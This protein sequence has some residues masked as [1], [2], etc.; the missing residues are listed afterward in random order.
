MHFEFREALR[1]CG[2]GARNLRTLH[3]FHHERI[4]LVSEI[5]EVAVALIL[6]LQVDT[7]GRTV[8]RDLRHLEGQYS[9]ILNRQA[10]IVESRHDIVDIM[11]ISLTVIPVLKTE[12]ERSIT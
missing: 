12:N 2:H 4:G 3:E 6:Y 5:G 10:I 1:E 9:R 11:L 8:T 7:V